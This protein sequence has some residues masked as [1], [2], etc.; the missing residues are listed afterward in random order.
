MKIIKVKMK[1][2]VVKLKLL[3]SDSLKSTSSKLLVR[4]D[5]T[6]FSGTTCLYNVN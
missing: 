2:G 3:I 4:S 1:S 6:N 5:T